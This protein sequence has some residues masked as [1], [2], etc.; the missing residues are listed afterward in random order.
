MLEGCG[1]LVF[2]PIEKPA[3]IELRKTLRGKGEVVSEARLRE[4][5]LELIDLYLEL[6]ER[7]LD[8]QMPELQNTDGD[9]LEPHTLVFGI[10]DPAAAAAALDAAKL[11]NGETIKPDG[12]RSSL[13]RGGRWR[14]TG[15]GRAPATRCIRAG[16]TR[17][18]GS[19]RSRA[20]S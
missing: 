13:R 18:S 4:R 16:P 2:Q 3:I 17:R 15:H 9:P 10:G 5:S 19:L 20:G 11:A 8:P 6:A 7:R 1:P 14:R 12:D